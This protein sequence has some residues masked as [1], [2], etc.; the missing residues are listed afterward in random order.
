MCKW[1]LQDGV[2]NKGY[3]I[4][5]EET[6]DGYPQY[7]LANTNEDTKTVTIK[8]CPWCSCRLK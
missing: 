8:Y 4:F 7:R 1:C 6:F 5:L 2:T 3:Y